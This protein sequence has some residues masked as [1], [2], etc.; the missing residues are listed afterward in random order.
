MFLFYIADND[1]VML[2]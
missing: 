2:K 1:D